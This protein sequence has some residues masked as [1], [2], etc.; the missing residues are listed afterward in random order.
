MAKAMTIGGMVVAGLLALVFGLDLILGVPFDGAST[1]MDIGF[2]LCGLILGY[3]SW[4]AFKGA[5]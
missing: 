1:W 4:N 2:L 5:K 3:M